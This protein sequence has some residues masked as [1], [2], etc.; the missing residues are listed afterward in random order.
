MDTHIKMLPEAN[1]C[2]Y[3]LCGQGINFLLLSKKL[4]KHV[5]VSADISILTNFFLLELKENIKVSYDPKQAFLEYSQNN[6][7]QILHYFSNIVSF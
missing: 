2:Q 6:W 5:V 7:K 4:K 3:P 1:W